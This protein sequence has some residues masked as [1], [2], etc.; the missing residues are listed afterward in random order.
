MFSKILTL[1]VFFTFFSGA[2]KE[3]KKVIAKVGDYN[4]TVSDF[5]QVYRPVEGVNIDSLKQVTLDNLTADKL[6]L[7]DA[8]EKGFDKQIE[9]QLNEHKNRLIVN[10]LYQQAVVKRTKVSTWEIRNYWWKLGTEVKAWHI[11]VKEKNKANE[12]YRELR[13]KKDFEQLARQYS[14]DRGTAGKG[15]DLGWFGWGRMDPN[16]QKVAFSLRPGQVSRPVHT[17]YGYHIIK[18]DAK[19]KIEKPDFDKEK[20]RIKQRL[21]RQKMGQLA[22]EYLKHLRAIAHIQYNPKTIR[23]L[24]KTGPAQ[25]PEDVKKM[26]LVSWAGGKVTVNDFLEKMGRR[27]RRASFDTPGAIKEQVNNWL[28]Y[29]NLLPLAAARHRF[30]YSPDIKKQLKEYKETLLLKEY[31]SIEISQRISVTDDEV[32]KYYKEHIDIY[33]E[34]F[35]RAKYRVRRD[36]ELEKRK[37]RELELIK[38]LKE[39]IPVQIFKETLE[40][41]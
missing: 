21:E 23:Q 4:I 10:A 13:K 34:N 14:E 20:D 30:D 40:I 16:F 15:G 39:K 36:I 19:R 9:P 35:D 2:Q 28:T 38:E 12:I 31:K 11:L 18:V 1:V 24:I 27:L 37:T 26:T 33:G 32:E 6:M 25:V 8:V 5:K 22:D 17:R 41:I 7:V 3:E 29:E